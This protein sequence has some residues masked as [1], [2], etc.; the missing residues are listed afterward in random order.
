MI[1]WLLACAWLLGVI[2]GAEDLS[3]TWPGILVAGACISLAMALSGE[4]RRALVGLAL[5][6]VLLGG[7]ARYE[8]ARLPATPSGIAT[9]NDSSQPERLRGSIAG[10]PEQRGSSQ[11][12]VVKVDSLYDGQSWHPTKGSLQVTARPFPALRYGDSLELNA[13]LDTPPSYEGFDYREYLARRG[14]VSLSA[15]PEVQRFGPGGS[16][17]AHA[18]YDLRDRL[19]AALGRALP[20]PEAALSQGILLGQRTAIP[21]DLNDDF[22]AAGISH[23][24]AISGYNVMIVAG[25]ALFVLRPLLGRYPAILASMLLV[26]LF[27]V[28]VGASP[29]VLRAMVMG[30]VLLGAQFFGRPGS[31][32]T[33]IGSAGALLTA[34]TPTIIEDVAFQLSF[35]ATLGI[36]LLASP[37]QERLSAPL[38]RLLP[39]GL[40]AWT[41]ESLSVTGA[42]S[43]AVLPVTLWTFGRIS[44]V[45]LPANLVAGEVF[46]LILATSALTAAVDT[47]SNALGQAAGTVAYLPLWLLVEIGRGFASLPMASI[48]LGRVGDFGG[49]LAVAAV[50]LLTRLIM[51]RPRTRADDQPG[52]AHL[53]WQL[54]AAAL[55]AV[56]AVFVWAQVLT[57]EDSGRLR[58]T[59]LD[60]GQGDSILIEAP[61]GARILVDGG[62]SGPALMQALG[63]ELP[64]KA[65]GFDLVVLTHGDED[66]VAGL[67]TLLERYSVEGVLMGPLRGEN[68]SYRAF[69][70]ALSVENVPV[71]NAVIGEHVDLGRGTRL[72]VLNPPEQPVR[73][74]ESLT[75][76]NSVVLRLSYGGVSFLL[77]GD[78]G[79]AGEEAVLASGAELHSSVL[80]VGHHGSESSTTPP[81]L[82]AIEPSVAVISVGA[83]NSYGHPSP[84]TR[85]RL[86]GVPVLR[87][88]LNGKVH[89]ETDGAHLWS[90]VGRGAPQTVDLAAIGR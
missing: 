82:D 89:F 65:R 80:K 18:L 55:I 17:I 73:G 63:R 12:Y 41:A 53:N 74:G 27:S 88:D 62:P 23:L 71:H 60:V 75:N 28:F 32:L 30:I 25:L 35:A 31:A 79:A 85:L 5:T 45:A 76:D 56:A 24:V 43:L 50:L 86:A 51:R 52:A 1:L 9:F 70:S 33:A 46:P 68:D 81:F 8:S 84:T 87:T 72:E 3:F 48:S 67:V 42:A 59:V 15:F 61:N 57:P 19:G 7:I 6:V 14:I 47:V 4:R 44:L 38:T 77:T 20:E 49:V 58:V 37:L 13:R 90:S 29:S 11:R 64:S 16:P 36:V 69:D 21:K 66:H 40:A 10:E 2:L 26:V 34:I 54:A 39:D 78:L 22:N 83:E